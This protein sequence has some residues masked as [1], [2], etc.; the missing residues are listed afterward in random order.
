MYKTN[1][2]KSIKTFERVFQRFLFNKLNRNRHRFC[3]YPNISCFAYPLTRTFHPN[4]RVRFHHHTQGIPLRP[5]N[6]SPIRRTA[7]RRFCICTVIKALFSPFPFYLFRR[8]NLH[9]VR[10]THEKYRAKRRQNDAH[11]KHDPKFVRATRFPT[12]TERK[13]NVHT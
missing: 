8:T 11:A 6:F 1:P 4:N 12:H 2:L 13:L 5:Y 7:C 10:H 9:F 3:N